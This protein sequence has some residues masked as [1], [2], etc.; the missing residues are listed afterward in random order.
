MSPD[1][2]GPMFR[3]PA[4]WAAELESRRALRREILAARLQAATAGRRSMSEADRK[5][6]RELL[7]AG[8]DPEE[9]ASIAPGL[10]WHQTETIIEL[11]ESGI[12]V[13]DSR[14]VTPGG[15]SHHVLSPMSPMERGM[16]TRAPQ[17]IVIHRRTGPEPVGEVF[18]YSAYWSVLHGLDTDAGAAILGWA[19]EHDI[20]AIYE[21][22]GGGFA[23]M[24]CC[25]RLDPVTIPEWLEFKTRFQPER[26]ASI[27]YL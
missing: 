25:L 15:G 12:N 27:P 18:D 20:T 11:E 23:D 10:G 5:E 26:E 4:E 9:I 24:A 8:L 16:S 14:V 7:A 17:K 1:D 21:D 19:R 13:N 6:I 22:Y 2:D 3:P